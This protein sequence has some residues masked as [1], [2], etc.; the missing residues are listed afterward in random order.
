[1]RA[2]RC[3]CDTT[4]GTRRAAV[5]ERILTKHPRQGRSGVNISRQKYDVIR[6]CM[7]ETLRAAGEMAFKDLTEEVR[8][9]LAGRF[10][11]SISWYVTTV[12]LD[13]EAR[14]IIERIPGKIPQRL[15]LAEAKQR[16]MR[17]RRQTT[18]GNT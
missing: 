17:G 6:E 3:H 15:R 2:A 13:L 11:G 16:F 18:N 12:K 14:G 1:M 8:H 10:D 5:E 7:V 4:F 9:I